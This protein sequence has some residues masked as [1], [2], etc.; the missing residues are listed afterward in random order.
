MKLGA[1]TRVYKKIFSAR[2][3]FFYSKSTLFEFELLFAVTDQV[4]LTTVMF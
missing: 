3:R 4:V 1:L 2:H